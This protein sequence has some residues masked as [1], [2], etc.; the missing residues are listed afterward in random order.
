MVHVDIKNTSRDGL[1]V[2]K[3]VSVEI[4]NKKLR[5]M[6]IYTIQLVMLNPHSVGCVYKTVNVGREYYETDES[7]QYYETAGSGLKS[8]I[9]TTQSRRLVCDRICLLQSVLRCTVISQLFHVFFSQLCVGMVSKQAGE[10][11]ETTES[12]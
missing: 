8:T 10:V 2:I 7:G 4:Y 12:H 1:W 11:A 3:R 9:V 6:N 5:S